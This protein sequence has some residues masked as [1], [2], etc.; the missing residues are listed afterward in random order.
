[1][2]PFAVQKLSSLTWFT[3]DL[4]SFALGDRIQNNIIIYVEEHSTLFSSRFFM[5][6]SLIFRSLILFEDF[7][8]CVCLCMLL[9]HIL[10]SFFCM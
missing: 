1:M 6:S 7:C 9:E 8:V 10:I 2:F 4:V 5:V 3:F